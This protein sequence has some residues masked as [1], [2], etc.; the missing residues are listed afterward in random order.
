MY[1]WEA[2]QELSPQSRSLHE[3]SLSSPFP[4][5]SL[6]SSCQNAAETLISPSLVRYAEANLQT[7]LFLWLSCSLLPFP[8]LCTQNTGWPACHLDFLSNRG[9]VEHVLLVQCWAWGAQK[10]TVATHLLIT[11]HVW[12]YLLDRCCKWVFFFLFVFGP[13]QKWNQNITPP[14]LIGFNPFS[15]VWNAAI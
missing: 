3:S 10:V 9:K 15:A 11:R 8:T 1:T 6:H 4:S 12:V 2:F 7:C 13:I 14:Y 5:H